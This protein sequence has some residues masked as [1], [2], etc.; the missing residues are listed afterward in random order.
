MGSLDRPMG[1][2]HVVLV[3]EE[4]SRV[5]GT[6]KAPNEEASELIAGAG[7]S[8]QIA[9][10]LRRSTN[11]VRN[12]LGAAS[13][14]RRPTLSP[15]LRQGRFCCGNE[16]PSGARTFFGGAPPAVVPFTLFSWTCHRRSYYCLVIRK[17]G[18]TT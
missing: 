16:S 13:H 7:R 3:V 12:R 15:R 9:H 11:P 1:P 17:L 4:A 18:F 5:V 10:M 6:E 8:P 14:L 2:N